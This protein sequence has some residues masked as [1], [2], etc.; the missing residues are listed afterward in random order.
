[1]SCRFSLSLSKLRPDS[2]WQRMYLNMVN[3][4]IILLNSKSI[5][6][7]WCFLNNKHPPVSFAKFGL[8][9]ADAVP[10]TGIFLLQPVKSIDDYKT[11]AVQIKNLSQQVDSDSTQDILTPPK[12]FQVNYCLFKTILKIQLRHVS[13]QCTD[14]SVG[15]WWWSSRCWPA[16]GRGSDAGR[17]QLCLARCTETWTT[18]P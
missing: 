11:K 15:W 12:T 18:E 4:L 17:E 10:C 13:K 1:M 3:S 9:E 2:F 5:G 7:T 8:Q 6:N 14:L 16:G